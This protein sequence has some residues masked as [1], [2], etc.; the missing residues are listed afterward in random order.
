MTRPA[1]L[2]VLGLF[3]CVL[4]YSYGGLGSFFQ[5]ILKPV[6]SVSEKVI[7]EAVAQSV[8]LQY[9]VFDADPEATEWVRS[10]FNRIVAVSERKD[11]KY[12]ITIL[13]P[14]FVNAFATPGGHIFVTKGLLQRVKSDDELAGV[15]GHEIAH[16]VAQHSMKSIKHQLVYQY[17]IK[18]LQKR[19]N[20]L[21]TM[22]QIYSIFSGLRYSRKNEL[23][24]DY[25]GA[26]YTAAAGYNPEG[27]VNFLKVLKSLESH[28]PSRIEVSLR[29]HPPSSRRIERIGAYVAEFSQEEQSREMR[30]SYNFVKKHPRR[31]KE[32]GKEAESSPASKVLSSTV[33]FSQGFEKN[34]EHPGIAEGLKSTQ[35]RGIFV[36]D[37]GVK[38]TGNSS[39][40][41]ST[42]GQKKSLALGTLP[43]SVS[44]S[45]LYQIRGY[46]KTSHVKAQEDPM[47]SGAFLNIQELSS[48]AFLKGHQGIARQTG[49]TK[50]FIEIQYEFETRKDTSSI[51]IEWVLRKARGSV[52]FDEFELIEIGKS[53]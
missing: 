29:S 15:L 33:V 39:Q 14:E 6:V 24:S 8:K 32:K 19:S 31:K 46:M 48:R 43:I 47:G 36:L 10:V 20:K 23:E 16:I 17:I 34:S 27:M 11:V 42:Y 21:E 3:L 5:K 25:I 45:T 41:I 1:F 35:D 51:I 50:D 30:L 53:L 44:P 26:R 13:R 7:G 49:T 37:K 22:G 52:W 4:P 38:K 12:R 18:K 9:G 28:D 40:R 2:I